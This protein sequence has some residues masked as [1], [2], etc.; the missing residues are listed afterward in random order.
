MSH[1][2]DEHPFDEFIQ[3]PE[4]N[5]RLAHAALLCACDEY[6]DLTPAHYLQRLNALADRVDSKDAHTGHER[7]D[8]LR[9]VLVDGE[10]YHGNIEDFGNPVNSYLNK[11]I[12]T[13]AGI[14]ISLSAIWIDVAAQLGW[15]FVGVSL[16]GHF[17]IRYDG[18]GEEILID[19]FNNGRELS[20]DDCSKMVRA[21]FG[22]EFSLT[23][24]H[25][26]PA[27][28]LAILARMLGNLY[29][30]YVQVNDYSR[31]ARVLSRIVAL[32]PEDAMV[33]AEL[34]RMQLL[35]G[36]LIGAATALHRA[37]E[38][39]QNAEEISTVNHHKRELRARMHEQ[40]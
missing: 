11:V 17:I 32:R 1:V 7:A 22:D 28:T 16:P 35:N 33:H 9:E 29:M 37:T 4:E 40:N 5:I 26:E 3:Q 38:L 23:E 13:R 10:M 14:P 31:T 27:G 24:Q 39:A 36:D 20:H 21:L 34:G 8:V 25:L 30:S 15:P 2:E 19:P 18:I 6:H 12:D